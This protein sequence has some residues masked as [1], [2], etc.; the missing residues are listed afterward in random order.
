[1]ATVKCQKCGSGKVTVTLAG[2]PYMPFVEWNEA[3]SKELGY[4][5]PLSERGEAELLLVVE[6]ELQCR[7]LCLFENNR[8]KRGTSGLGEVK[9]LRA[10]GRLLARSA[11]ARWPMPV[12]GDYATGWLFAMPWTRGAAGRPLRRGYAAF[13]L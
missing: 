8:K 6:K 12:H 13:T 11:R 7:K 5:R 1:M 10:G 3:K 4:L 2:K 9:T